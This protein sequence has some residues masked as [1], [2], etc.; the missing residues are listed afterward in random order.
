MM[1]LVEGKKPV[2]SDARGRSRAS[3]PFP[4]SSKFM[5]LPVVAVLLAGLCLSSLGPLQTVQGASLHKAGF[6]D[7]NRLLAGK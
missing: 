1:N 6:L 3:R 2:G 4:V 5:A 7:I